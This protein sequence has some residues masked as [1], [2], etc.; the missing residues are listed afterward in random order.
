MKTLDT[1]NFEKSIASEK[2]LFIIKFFSET[3]G[4]CKTMVPV[5]AALEQNN[6]N[7][8][9]YEIDTG[10][11]A[12]LAAQ[13]GVRGVPNIVYCDNREVIYRFV[14]ITPLRDLQYVIDNIDDPH[15]LETGSFLPAQAKKSYIF[16]VIISSLVLGFLLLL[17]I[18]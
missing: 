3:C 4:P 6:T 1:S 12:E 9:I 15:F 2:G 16:P 18:F 10:A 11:S 7:I 8:S 5:V 13:F 17:F 14:G